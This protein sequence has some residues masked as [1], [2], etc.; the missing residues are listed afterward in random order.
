MNRRCHSIMP[1]SSSW[2]TMSNPS[3]ASNVAVEQDPQMTLAAIGQL[4]DSRPDV[5]RTNY[6]WSAA[7]AMHDLGSVFIGLAHGRGQNQAGDDPAPPHTR[8]RPGTY[9][10][11]H[12]A[13]R[14]SSGAA[15]RLPPVA[16]ESRNPRRARSGA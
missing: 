11:H 7:A 10:V 16:C 13:A 3:D 12:D 14:S 15:L 1:E 6:P 4:R 8:A 2:S 5:A 9:Q